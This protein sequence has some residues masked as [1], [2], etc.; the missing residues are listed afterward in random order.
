MPNSGGFNPAHKDIYEDYDER[1]FAPRMINCWIPICGVNNKT[2]LP[3]VPG[4]HDFFESEILR[5]KCN[6]IVENRQY[7]VNCIQSWR[8]KNNLELLSPKSG[9]MLIFSSHLIHGLGFNN[10]CNETRISLE[11]RLHHQ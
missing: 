10:N 8:S 7:S 1:G 3:L 11:F 2:G 9:E 4:S 5:T 6:S